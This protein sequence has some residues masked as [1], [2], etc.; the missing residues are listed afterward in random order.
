MKPKKSPQQNPQ[1]NLFKSELY[2]MINPA[3]PLVKISKVVDWTKPDEISEETFS[4]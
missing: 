4:P 2:N 3:H 1:T